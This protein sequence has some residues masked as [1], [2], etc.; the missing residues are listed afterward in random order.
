[1]FARRKDV[2]CEILISLFG[3]FRRYYKDSPEGNSYQMPPELIKPG[4]IGAAI[5]PEDNDWHR[6]E[7]LST[8]LENKDFV[9]VSLV[10]QCRT[11]KK[12]IISSSSSLQKSQ[13]LLYFRFLSWTTGDNV[14][15]T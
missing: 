9:D 12:L 14:R 13:K 10:D 5:F 15:F 11:L 7:I 8:A 6:V 4:Q 3:H 2:C 1:M